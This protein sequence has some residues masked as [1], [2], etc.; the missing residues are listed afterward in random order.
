MDYEDG[1]EVEVPK[2]EPKEELGKRFFLAHLNTY[3]GMAL[4]KELKN[5]HL[6]K[7][8]EAAHTFYGTLKKDEKNYVG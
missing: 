8:P 5:A 7:D 4:L 2:E 3:T 1:E 6:V